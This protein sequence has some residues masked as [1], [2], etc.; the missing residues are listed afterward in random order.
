MQKTVR[1]NLMKEPYPGKIHFNV[2]VLFQ[3]AAIIHR[4]RKI[5]RRLG[6]FA[7][8][9]TPVTAWDDRENRDQRRCSGEWAFCVHSWV[10]AAVRALPSGFGFFTHVI[11]I[12]VSIVIWI[13]TRGPIFSSCTEQ[14]IKTAAMPGINTNAIFIFYISNTAGSQAR[15]RRH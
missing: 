13:R 2:P 12:Y 5:K 3:R 1:R 11:A 8:G 10:H 9:E 4:Y 15:E 7:L 14:N 6:A